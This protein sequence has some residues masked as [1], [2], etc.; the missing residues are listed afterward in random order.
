MR[1]IVNRESR[2][3][4]Q[5]RRF[6]AKR[7]GMTLIEIVIVV[8]ILGVTMAVAIPNMTGV[9]RKNKLNATARELIALAK[10]ARAEAVFGERT[11]ELI[12]DLEKHEFWLDLRRPDP[13]EGRTGTITGGGRNSKK[14]AAR[15]MLEEKH[16]MPSGISFGE[17]TAL[18]QNILKGK[19]IAIDFYPD[20][21]ASPTI[22]SIQ[23][24]RK[25]SI[26]IEI[27]KANGMAEMTPGTV[28]QKQAAIEEAAM[29]APLPPMGGVG[30]F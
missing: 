13:N 2:I 7:R 30:G 25:Q 16:T 23:N 24:D 17:A 8:V 12:L 3:A 1:R 14:Q 27:L 29:S 11:T 10:A 6:S 20:G 5:G 21:T 15:S 18:D 22:F 19:L 28:E 4:D 26:T 9:N